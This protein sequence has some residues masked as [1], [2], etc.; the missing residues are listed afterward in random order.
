MGAQKTETRYI[1]H[2]EAATDTENK[3]NVYQH[4]RANGITFGIREIKQVWFDYKTELEREEYK[5]IQDFIKTGGVLYN[6]IGVNI[7]EVVGLK[8]GEYKKKENKKKIGSIMHLKSGHIQ[9]KWY[10]NGKIKRKKWKISNPNDLTKSNN[11][12]RTKDQALQLAR[13]FQVCVCG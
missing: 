1:Q 13:E 10:V 5:T 12:R 8:Q 9:F 11:S 7:K 6:E 4:I 2:K 3:A